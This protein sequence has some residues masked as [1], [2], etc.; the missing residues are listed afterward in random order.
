MLKSLTR[1]FRKPRHSSK[2]LIDRNSVKIQDCWCQVNT[3]LD[4]EDVGPS[5]EAGHIY[6]R[7]VSGQVWIHQGTNSCRLVVASNLQEY[8]ARVLSQGRINPIWWDKTSVDEVQAPDW[9]TESAKH[10]YYESLSS[11]T[12]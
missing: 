11:L 3:P 5:K 12:V 7:D 4:S 2:E 10:D 6:V 1:L 9:S 8:C